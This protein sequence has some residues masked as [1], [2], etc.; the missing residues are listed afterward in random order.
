M[1]ASEDEFERA[2]WNNQFYSSPAVLTESSSTNHITNLR[3]V[4]NLP[5]SMSMQSLSGYTG[6]SDEN[7]RENRSGTGK[8]GDLDASSTNPRDLT[9]SVA[10]AGKRTSLMRVSPSMKALENALNSDSK[11]VT[12]PEV[13][14]EEEDE[15]EDDTE[16]GKEAEFRSENA[17]PDTQK[18][19]LSPEFD[20]RFQQQG[21]RASAFSLSTFHTAKSSDTFISG[22]GPVR[23]ASVTTIELPG[24]LANADTPQLPSGSLAA[25]LKSTAS[26]ETSLNGTIQSQKGNEDVELHTGAYGFESVPGE[27]PNKH[28]SPETGPVSP[29]QTQPQSMVPSR[30]CPALSDQQKFAP[31]APWKYARSPNNSEPTSSESGTRPSDSQAKT[32][33]SGSPHAKVSKEKEPSSPSK[34]KPVRSLLDSPFL[35]SGAEAAKTKPSSSAARETKGQLKGQNHVSP[36]KS[37]S[38]F[39]TPR[40]K[41]RSIKNSPSARSGISESTSISEPHNN[42][43]KPAVQSSSSSSDAKPAQHKRFS[44]RG[45]FR[46]KSKNHSLS[47][48]S[49]IEEELKHGSRP[50]KLSAKSYSTPNMSALANGTSEGNKSAPQKDPKIQPKKSFFG[51]KGSSTDSNK[52]S[53]SISSHAVSH[54]QPTEKMSFQDAFTKKPY[55]ETK[56]SPKLPAPATP[57]AASSVFSADTPSTAYLDPK[58]ETIREVDDSDYSPNISRTSPVPSDESSHK[59]SLGGE[60]SQDSD[61]VAPPGPAYGNVSPY[62]PPGSGNCSTSDSNSVTQFGSPFKVSF[63][64]ERNDSSP[65]SPHSFRYQ[66]PQ[67]PSRSM[68]SRM[69]GDQLAGET[70]FPKSLDA[71]E[72]ESIVSLERSRSMRS[73]R[74]NK[75]SSFLNY[76]GSDDNIIL[77]KTLGG[78]SSNSMKRSGSILKNSPSAQSVQPEKYQSIDTAF[79]NGVSET[80]ETHV[81][82]GQAALSN[83]D[84]D[85][86][87][88]IEF[89]DYIDF[90]NLDFSSSPLQQPFLEPE[91]DLV[92][93]S[94]GIFL[95]DEYGGK[96][97]IF[98]APQPK[99]DSEPVEEHSAADSVSAA[100]TS[101][102]IDTS[103]SMNVSKNSVKAP[104]ATSEKN[105]TVPEPEIINISSATSSD[106]DTSKAHSEEAVVDRA[107]VSLDP[108]PSE[109]PLDKTFKFAMTDNRRTNE[110]SSR[111]PRPVSMSFKGFS[112]STFKDKVLPQSG[113][114]QS[115]HFD[116][117]YSVDDNSV[118]GQG[119]GSSDEDSD[120]DSD[121]FEQSE[122]QQNFHT[123]PGVGTNR[124][125]KKMTSFDRIQTHRKNTLDLQPPTSLP[126]HH[127]RI[128]SI[129]DQSSV[130]SPKSLTSFITRMRK[131]P[132][133]SPQL[134]PA[135]P[136]VKFSSRIILYDT[137]H[138]E[139]YDRHPEPATCNSLTAALASQIKE[140]LNELK[141]T[142]EVHEESVCYT[143]YF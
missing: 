28:V 74:S 78:A 90:D 97:P 36:V 32:D 122:D 93:P 26:D 77:G 114:H 23:Q 85:F 20:I 30:S 50:V 94:L 59:S 76:D 15:N 104:Q 33:E 3:K 5:N 130:S 142:M 125:P 112:G 55:E 14:A 52:E 4:V 13:I 16:N 80:N 58:R 64:A 41:A 65:R 111:A 128:P 75:R 126:F 99:S 95:E 134:P 73:I 12:S 143:Q 19:D 110:Q 49:G 39:A 42:D 68:N 107:D 6:G 133:A 115:I 91:Q 66:P 17:L 116:D 53:A 22:S 34:Q 81:E 119:F 46:I 37:S 103:T 63:P 27:T 1:S 124:A 7:K 139:E 45:L 57:A 96:S 129:S 83:P 127:N 69:S 35:A 43:A 31:R 118:V 92:S 24:Y 67:S 88:F 117:D 18:T 8:N 54:L 109:S 84:T 105:V 61:S 132:M 51:R 70:L 123:A 98:E 137:Y 56:P 2:L 120:D 40:S 102:A 101:T 140:E 121:S 48:L 86:A 136:T 9:G 79:E 108:A 29:H 100:E 11:Q 47:K 38:A 135:R 138:H 113:S 72:V 71:H 62:L 44:F 82:T 10:P 21:S 25:S 106:F 141:S 87:D 131:S 89:S 60:Q